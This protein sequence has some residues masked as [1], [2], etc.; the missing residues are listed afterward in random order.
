M[1][2]ELPEARKKTGPS[3]AHAHAASVSQTSHVPTLCVP[4]RGL[5]LL[6]VASVPCGGARE[7][8]LLWPVSVRPKPPH[9]FAPAAIFGG[10]AVVALCLAVRRSFRPSNSP[11]RGA[12]VRAYFPLGRCGSQARWLPWVPDDYPRPTLS[13]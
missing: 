12:G 1:S 8:V 2:L 9:F 11:S 6:V 7:L 3:E 13:T 5:T 10:H 4:F